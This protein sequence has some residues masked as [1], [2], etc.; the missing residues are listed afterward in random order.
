MSAPPTDKTIQ[1]W[2]R[3]WRCRITI[4]LTFLSFFIIWINQ[5]AVGGTVLNRVG[6]IK[7]RGKIWATVTFLWSAKTVVSRHVLDVVDERRI[8]QDGPLA[9]QPVDG[10]FEGQF[11]TAPL[12]ILAKYS[13]CSSTTQLDSWYYCYCYY[14]YGQLLIDSNLTVSLDSGIPSPPSGSPM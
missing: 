2:R 5:G 13:S 7:R 12:L 9:V 14:Y 3:R 6:L 8:W 1:Q 11:C 4:I 10:V